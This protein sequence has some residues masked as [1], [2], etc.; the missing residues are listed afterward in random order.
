VVKSLRE[1]GAI[2][3]QGDHY[4]LARPLE[5][6]VVPDII[7]DVLMARI[8]RL[9]EAPKK[10]LQLTAVIGREFTR[11]LLDRPADIHERTEAYLQELKALELVYERR[12]FPELSYM[13]KHAL[14]Q[15]VAYNSLLMQRRQEL[16]RLIG[17]AIEELYADRLAEADGG[18]RGPGSGT[19]TRLLPTQS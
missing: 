9:E 17:L 5:E 16:H 11:H 6:L 12:L 19:I 1:T 10:T 3:R 15:D 8:D 18:P 14:T 2:R 4:I 13:F 7:Q